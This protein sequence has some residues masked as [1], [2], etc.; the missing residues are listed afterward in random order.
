MENPVSQEHNPRQI[1]IDWVEN[2][3]KD[4]LRANNQLKNARGKKNKDQFID[5]ATDYIGSIIGS[6]DAIMTIIKQ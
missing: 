3:R 2:V 5:D 1:F 6:C 4:A